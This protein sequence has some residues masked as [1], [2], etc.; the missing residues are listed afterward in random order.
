MS[1]TPMA[2]VTVGLRPAPIA[3]FL[4]CPASLYRDKAMI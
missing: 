4:T 2:A 3:A 1:I